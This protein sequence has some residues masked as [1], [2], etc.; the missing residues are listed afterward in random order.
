[1]VISVG[2]LIG[3]AGP[4]IAGYLREITGSLSSSIL[5][6]SAVLLLSAGL[7]ALLPETGRKSG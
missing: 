1:M 7:V 3:A 6:L 4:S 2:Y 5:M